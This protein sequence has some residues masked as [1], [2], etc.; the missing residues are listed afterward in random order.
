MNVF[1]VILIGV[2]LAMD[3]FGVSLGIGVN[4]V[5]NRK[6]KIGYII[7]FAF[8]Q[9]L[10]TFLGGRMGY[11]F[12]TYIASIPHI[13]GGA[14]IAFIGIFMIIE[15][16]KE[17]GDSILTKGSM[18][19]VLGISVSIDALVVGFTALHHIGTIYILLVDSILIGFIS[20]LICTIAFFLCRYIRKI[21]FVVKY[22]DF[23]GGVALIFFAI[24]LIFF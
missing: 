18:V 6:K 8:F 17:K 22:A 20:A 19:I 23:F 3:A 15:G 11:L 2:A 1:S 16:Y 14:V 21:N 4:S 10:L 12:D 13:L 24:K 5:I 9:F 7:S